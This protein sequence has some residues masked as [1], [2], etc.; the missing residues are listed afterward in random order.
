MS[1]LALTN[2]VTVSV[3]T[4]SPGVGSYNTSNLALFTDDAPASGWSGASLGYAAYLTPT[5]VGLDF[6]TTS[7][8]YAMANAVFSQQ[9]NILTGGGQLIIILLKVG[10]QTLTLSGVAAS[11]AFTISYGGNTTTSLPY[12]STAAQIQTALELLTGLAQWQV[13]GS[14]ASESL[15]ITAYGTYGALGSITFPSNTL[16]TAGSVAITITQVATVTGETIGAAITRTAGLVQYFGILVNE[17]VGTSQVIPSADVTAAAAIVLPLNK[18]AFFVTNSVTDLTATTGMIALLTSAAYSNTRML[19]YGD[20]TT[21][22]VG[23]QNA[24]VMSASYASL[25]LSV[26]FNGSLTTTTMHLK[27]LAGVSPDPSMTQTILNEAVACGADTYV[28][29][30]GVSAVFC[31][32][33]NSFYD[34]VYNQQWFVGALQVAGF[35]YLAQTGTKVPQTEAGMTGLKSAYRAVCEQGV[36]N[37]YLAGGSW[38]SATTFGNP[39]Q[40]ISNVS[41]RGYYIYSSPVALQAQTARAARQAPLVQ[42]AAKQACAIQSSTV[43]V[44]INP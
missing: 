16:Q 44:N 30:Q 13:T 31:S 2:I 25:G 34:Q 38:N 39:A 7:K 11:G 41:Q 33:A 6:G 35:N 10:V 26:N 42:I 22:G 20:T 17:S 5:Q 21:G 27:V 29:L 28:S 12:T 15:V 36:T 32:G 37:G 8:T 4:S 1:Q 18:I 14:I 24:L 40:L 19:Y 43:I 3:S 23:V 9:P